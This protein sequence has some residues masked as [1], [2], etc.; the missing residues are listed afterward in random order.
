MSQRTLQRHQ[1]SETVPF[2]QYSESRVAV[3][4]IPRDKQR[5][6]WMIILNINNLIGP[7]VKRSDKDLCGIFTELT[8][9]KSFFVSLKE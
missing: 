5:Q 8:C 3:L 1:L 4:R 9:R 2:N 7:A 6:P